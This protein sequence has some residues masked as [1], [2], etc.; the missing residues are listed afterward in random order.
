MLWDATLHRNWQQGPT[1]MFSPKPAPRGP[2]ED[3]QKT[4][5]NIAGFLQAMCGESM[6]GR[7]GCMVGVTIVSR[8]VGWVVRRCCGLLGVW[9]ERE[10]AGKLPHGYSNLSR[11]ECFGEFFLK[12]RMCSAIH[13]SIIRE[14]SARSALFATLR[15]STVCRSA[16]RRS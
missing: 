3:D 6:G 16:P 11:L 13:R 8:A 2:I 1:L 9:G 14:W 15:I 4:K 12:L 7:R 5:K 10:D